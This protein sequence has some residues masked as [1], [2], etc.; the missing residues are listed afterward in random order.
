VVAGNTLM[1]S[2]PASQASR[3][4]VGVKHPGMTGMFRS[5]HASMTDRRATGL[6]TNCAPASTTRWTVSASTTVPAPKRNPLGIRGANSR[7]NSTAPGTLIVTSS[8]RMPP[9]EIA[10]T[11]A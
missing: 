7:I 6:T 2:A 8:A 4:S 3:I 5:A 10:S 9:S 1:M 11:T